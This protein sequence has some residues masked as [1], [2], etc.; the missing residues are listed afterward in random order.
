[1][2]DNNLLSFNRMKTVY[3]L[4]TKNRIAYGIVSIQLF[5]PSMLDGDAGQLIEYHQGIFWLT[6]K[7][8]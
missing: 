4:V 7:Q 5:M 2:S 8:I 3:A 6:G 1:M